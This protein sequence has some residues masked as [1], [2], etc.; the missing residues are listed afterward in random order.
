MDF[1]WSSNGKTGLS[2][3]PARVKMPWNLR[4]DVPD[5]HSQEEGSSDDLS[6]D[7]TE[8]WNDCGWSGWMDV[9]WKEHVFRNDLDGYFI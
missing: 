5:E 8:V 9:S 7:S 3:V 2:T 1:V 4:P 6:S